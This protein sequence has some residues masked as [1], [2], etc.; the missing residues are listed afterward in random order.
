MT[1][2][3]TD[4]I[5]V[6]QYDLL[7]P[8][9]Y[10]YHDPHT[11]WAYLRAHRPV[12]RAPGGFWVVTRYDDVA[13]VLR[14]SESF[15][16]RHGTM[17][18][19]LHA[20]MPDL[21]SDEMMP[22]SDPPRHTWLRA[23]VARA[24]AHRV[25]RRQ[26]DR[27]SGIVRDLLAPARDGVTIDLAD[28]ALMFPMAFTGA[29]MG[30]PEEDWPRLATLTTMTIAYT[31][32]AYASGTPQQTLM[33][34]HHELFACFADELDRRSEPRDPPEDLIDILMSMLVDGTPLSREQV[35]LNAYSLLL[36]ANVT[37]PHAATVTVRAMAEN[38][39]QWQ[40]L[41]ADPTLVPDA[42]EEGLRWAS[43]AMHFMRH[44]VKDIELDGH[45]IRAGEPVSAWIASANRDERVFT[46]PYRFDLARQPN[47]HLT[48][49]FG[50]H[51]CIGAGIARLALQ[52]L[53]TELARTVDHIEVAGEAVPLESNF[54]AGL[55]HL[56]MRFV[57]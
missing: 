49:G 55:K 32:P 40:R 26:Q 13:R 25:V 7:D 51:Y 10:A 56:P 35:L 42:V 24:L 4:V 34:A 29:L 54:V 36:G 1:A 27:L 9:T 31:D 33:R 38:P 5:D 17:L 16:S 21:A 22:D 57:R 3:A 2:P 20:N 41:K 23:P 47:R 11:I 50:A 6:D 12:Y 28:A 8:H 43:P 48:F 44:A 14:D 46:E 45:L 19:I 30:V 18:S 15:S 52:T 39:E 37:T 53:L